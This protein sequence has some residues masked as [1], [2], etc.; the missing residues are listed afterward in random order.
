MEMPSGTIGTHVEGH[1]P[2][3]DGA[4]TWLGSPPLTPEGLGG[5]VVLVDFWTFTCINWLRTA[6]YIRAWAQKYRAAGLVVI[7][8]HTPEF[9]F[10]HDLDRVRSE[11]ERR[12]IDYP[13][14][15]DNDYAIWSAFSNH[16]WPALYAVDAQGAIRHHHFGE[17]EYE[18]IERVIQELLAESGAGGVDGG[19]VSVEG[20][21]DEAAAD[22]GALES[23][24]TYLGYERTDSFA[25]PG[26]ATLDE[27]RTYSLPSDL[28]LHHWALSG[29]WTLGP[30]AVSLDAA[31]GGIAF[32]FRAR[33]VHLVTG[34]VASHAPVPFQVT[35]DGEPPGASH[36]T[37]VGPDG[38]GVAAE[39]RLHQL[40][41]QRGGV[42]ECT[43]EVTFAEAGV[44]AYVFT[45]G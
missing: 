3:F 40:V 45:F 12:G 17:G 37:D 29:A 30:G 1:L 31:G 19:L 42:R 25:S 5:K 4:T 34:P 13:V 14:A 23:P 18:R 24:E 26:G 16:Y 38:R 41:R 8:V 33:D 22:W 36:G 10:E 11:I 35:I 32:R 43:F 28:Q 9:G 21:G 7:G 20:E 44:A 27:A 6:P 39:R 15:V 2:R